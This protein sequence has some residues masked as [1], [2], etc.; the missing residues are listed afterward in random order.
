MRKQASTKKQNPVLYGLICA[1]LR[2]YLKL[3]YNYSIPEDRPE[4]PDGPVLVLGSHS[5]NL[6]FLFA[7]PVLRKK[8]FNIVVTS[9]FFNNKRL[10]KLLR[11]FHCIEKEQ[12]RADVAAIRDMRA[13]IKNGA[14]VLVYPEGEVNGTG[15]TEPPEKN[16][17]RLCRMMD[18]PIYAI[19][20]HGSYFT[21]PKWGPVIRRGRVEAE[22]VP[23]A[24][25]CDEL[26]GLCDAELY[27]RICAALAVN[28]YDWQRSAR[29]PFTHIN[30]AEGLH[31]LLYMC[32]RCGREYV[33]NS[34]G[35][36][37][38]CE[39]CGNRGRM[40]EF[41]FLHP[42]GP[43]DIIPGTVPEWVD[44]ERESIR[45]EFACAKDHRIASRAYL[46][47]HDESNTVKSTDV[48][49]G[50]VSLDRNELVYEG[51]CNGEDVRLM[52]PLSSFVK[53]PFCIGMQF[54]VPNPVRY[55]SIRPV[56]PREVQKFVL[57]V[58]VIKGLTE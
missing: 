13:S 15:R 48:G 22:V 52:Y 43:D 47:F 10:A 11:F 53:L 39:S 40:D 31:N 32:P 46:Q 6:D 29:V 1:L 9:Y 16:I 41:G 38:F 23:V 50:T 27:G 36:E 44:I 26:H 51:T 20:T 45:R 8:R 3:L 34:K 4:L 14:S 25:T 54:D 24:V 18:V 49:C 56:N 5:S 57:A 2:P 21:R 42:A 28:D 35:A 12:F 37:I 55:T 58:P 17:T 19:R 33:M 30:A 7:L